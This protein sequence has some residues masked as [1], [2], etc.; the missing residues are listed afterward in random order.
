MRTI[1]AYISADPG[2]RKKSFQEFILNS[3]KVERINEILNKAESD[4][5]KDIIG[6][7]YLFR[8]L[9]TAYLAGGHVLIEGVPGLAKTRAAKKI[10]TLFDTTFS[11]IQF[12]PDLLPSDITGNMVYRPS[13]G[14]FT[15]RRG[16]VFSGVLLADEINR[17]PAKVQ[18]ALL[19]A[20]EERQVTIGDES[21]LLPAN[22]FVIATQNP[23]EHE[24]TYRLP[25]AQLDRFMM[26]LL[27]DYPKQDEEVRILDLHQAGA[28]GIASPSVKIDN[29]LIN[30]I[31]E[32]INTVQVS[33][34]VKEYIVAVVRATREDSRYIGF[35]SSPRGAVS[36]LKCSRINAFLEGRD[37]VLPEDIKETASDLLRHRIILT[38]EAEADRIKPDELIDEILKSVKTP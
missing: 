7:K 12:T 34:A 25:E 31:R 30:E 32:N 9:L 1:L 10:S 36:I 8:K 24:G 15:V 21:L 14:D 28:S 20:M 22:F 5:E 29:E 2:K 38:F 17:A 23:I 4:F 37:W 6:G 11:R 27:L 35:G 33:D 18:S 13:T 26:K 19:E 3:E 16:P